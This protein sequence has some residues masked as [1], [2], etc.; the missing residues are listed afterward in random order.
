LIPLY[1]MTH[2]SH[3]ALREHVLQRKRCRYLRNSTDLGHDKTHHEEGW[4]NREQQTCLEK[5]D[6][7]K[8]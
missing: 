8:E 3:L 5:Y 1:A 4:T 2:S 6:D 7:D